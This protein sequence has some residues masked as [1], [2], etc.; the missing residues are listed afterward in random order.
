MDRVDDE[1]E[2]LE[3]DCET[4]GSGCFSGV[5]EVSVT[6]VSSTDSSTAEAF[7]LSLAS[8]RVVGR[9]S[10]AG[11]LPRPVRFSFD[12]RQDLLY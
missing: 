5:S 1:L 10:P 12:I 7:S 9:S 3:E 6:E 2:L 8:G 4:A 11:T